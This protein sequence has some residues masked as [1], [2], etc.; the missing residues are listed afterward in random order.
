MP[1]KYSQ[2]NG[3]EKSIESFDDIALAPSLF[4]SDEIYT[5]DLKLQINYES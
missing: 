2:S 4:G 5:S 3:L 1:S